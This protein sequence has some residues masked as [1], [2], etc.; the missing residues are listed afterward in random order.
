MQ[1]ELFQGNFKTIEPSYFLEAMDMYKQ[2]FRFEKKT[3]SKT[4][5]NSHW[6]M[7][8]TETF[9]HFFPHLYSPSY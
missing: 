4:T 5:L 9:N 7:R 3:L 6:Y 8:K 1:I 2:E